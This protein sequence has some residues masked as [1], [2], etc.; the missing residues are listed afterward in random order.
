[1][2]ES[3]KHYGHGRWRRN[4]AYAIVL[5]Y[6]AQGHDVEWIAQRLGMGRKFVAQIFAWADSQETDS[7]AS[8]DARPPHGSP[9]SERAQRAERWGGRESSV[10][11]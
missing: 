1:V 9:E 2:S 4:R 5:T 7:P 10:T 3:A 11:P 6:R 8:D